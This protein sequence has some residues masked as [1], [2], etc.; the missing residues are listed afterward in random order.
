MPSATHTTL[1]FVAAPLGV[2]FEH[3]TDGTASSE[4]GRERRACPGVCRRPTRRSRRSPTRSRSSGGRDPELIRVMSDEQVLVPWPAAPLASREA[5]RSASACRAAGQSDWSE[6]A[7]VEAGLLCRRLDGAVRE[8][9]RLG[10]LGRRPRRCSRASLARAGRRGARS[11]VRHR[12]RRLHRRRST[13]AASATTCSRPA[14]RATPPAALPDLRRHRPGSRGRRTTSRCCS[15]TGGSAAGS[16]GATGARSTATGWRC[17]RNS[18]S[19]PPTAPSTSS[20]PTRPGPRAR[21]ACSPTISTTASAPTS[22]RGAATARDRVE[23]IEASSPGSSRPTARRSAPPETLPAARGAPLAVRRDARRLRAE[24]RRLGPAAASATPSP[25]T[26]VDGPARRG[27]RGRR[28]RRPAA[29]HG[30]GDRQLHPRAAAPRCSSRASPSTASATPRSPGCRSCAPRTSRP[31]SSGSDL[32][33]TGWFSSS[34]ERLNRFHENVV[35]S[36]RGNFLDVPT[37][38]PQRDERLGWTGDVQVFSPAGDVPVRRDRIPQLVA[39]RPRGRA[40]R[41]RLRAV[42]GARTCS[43]TPARPPRAGATPRRSSRGS[44]TSAPATSR[45][46]RASSRACARGSTAIAALAGDDHLWTGGFQFGDW[47]D[48]D[49]AARRRR[50]RARPTPTWSPPPTSPARPRS[51]SVAA[52]LLGE[53]D[54]ADRYARLADRVRGAFAREY[55]TGG[56]RVLSDA[57][58]V[59]ALA[60]EWSLLPTEEQRRRA[61]ERLADLVRTAGFRIST[62]FLGTPLIADALTSPATSTSPT[63]C[64][65]RRAARHGSTR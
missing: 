36:M 4:S 61:G 64:C 27:A 38:C 62:G 25:A 60:L 20:P 21:A 6:P 9:A 52:T 7:T 37:D 15:A 1:S 32:R 5:A 13:G 48:P 47:L 49:R 18:R 28:A 50:R 56:G 31:S 54:V 53:L 26:E 40:A 43:A 16:A 58:T 55:V 30:Q 39:G 45:C 33:R 35:W 65:C 24:P 10:G 46:S 63:G 41:G 57:A 12:A 23:V 22:G 3:R 14:G 34:D 2:R 59:Y 51:S 19:R 11:P 29:A 44:S 8:P 42:R 17:S